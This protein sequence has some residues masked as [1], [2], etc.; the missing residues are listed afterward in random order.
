MSMLQ[1]LHSQVNCFQRSN[2]KISHSKQKS[3]LEIIKRDFLRECH[4]L[5]ESKPSVKEW[6]VF[7]FLRKTVMT[8]SVWITS[9]R[10]SSEFLMLEESSRGRLRRVWVMELK[11]MFKTEHNCWVPGRQELPWRHPLSYAKKQ[12]RWET[13][14]KSQ[15][16]TSHSDKQ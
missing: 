16:K 12:H 10:F 7:C 9:S 8:S 5:T 15:L 1:T 13:W 11:M 14:K 3:N 2:S 4:I 6:G